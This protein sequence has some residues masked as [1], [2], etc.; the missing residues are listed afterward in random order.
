MKKK[1]EIEL[2]ALGSARG[3]L[4]SC[5]NFD[6]LSSTTKKSIFPKDHIFLTCLKESFPH[7]SLLHLHRPFY[8]SIR[9]FHYSDLVLPNKSRFTHPYPTVLALLTRLVTQCPPLHKPTLQATPRQPASSMSRVSPP[10]RPD[11]FSAVPSLSRPWLSAP[12]LGV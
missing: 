8:I 4:P 12:G 2:V 6:T 5:R 7:L 9:P 11:S 10:M 1:R 3:P